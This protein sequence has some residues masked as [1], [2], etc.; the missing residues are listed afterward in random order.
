[1]KKLHVL[2]ALAFCAACASGPTVA[3]SSTDTVVVRYDSLL[4][5]MPDARDV[6]EK[7][8]QQYGRHAEFRS[9]DQDT[10]HNHLATFACIK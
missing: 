10:E 6:A 9:E 8:C 2:A 1:M 5:Q 7:A 4:N 3:K